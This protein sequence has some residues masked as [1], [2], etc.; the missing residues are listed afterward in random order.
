MM[1]PLRRK[2]N[3]FALLCREGPKQV[4]IRGIIRGVHNDW[5]YKNLEATHDGLIDFKLEEEEG[6]KT[7]NVMRIRSMRNVAFEQG[8]HQ[9]KITDKFKVALEK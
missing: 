7:Q 6:G 1:I 5:A 3:L 2:M 4:G 8:W 9:L